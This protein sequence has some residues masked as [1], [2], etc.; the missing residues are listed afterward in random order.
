LRVVD[1]LVVLIGADAHAIARLKIP[2]LR[3][4]AGS[5]AVFR[6]ARY[7]DGR[8]HFVVVLNDHVLVFDFAQHADESCRVRL[9]ALRGILLRTPPAAGISAATTT[10][11]SDAGNDDLAKTRSAGQQEKGR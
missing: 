1:L 10:G 2:D 7:R 11:K 8:D 6:R 9:A 5:A 4:A 3:F